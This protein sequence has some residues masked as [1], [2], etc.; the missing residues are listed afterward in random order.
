[1]HLQGVAHTSFSDGVTTSYVSSRDLPPTLSP[2]QAAVVLG[3]TAADFMRMHLPTTEPSARNELAE[4]F[5]RCEQNAFENY[6]KPWRD[7]LHA[8]V[9]GATTATAQRVVLGLSNCSEFGDA[10]SPEGAAVLSSPAATG[11]TPPVHAQSYLDSTAETPAGVTPLLDPGKVTVLR[12]RQ[13]NTTPSIAQRLP[14]LFHDRPFL[15]SKPLIFLPAALGH[16]VATGT[17]GHAQN[18]GASEQSTH[19]DT[20]TT[21]VSAVEVCSTRP[22]VKLINA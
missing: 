2:A 11:G 6:L 4:K 15:F 1:M 21:P 7:A 12:A 10:C 5:R 22:N 3:E 20:V 13:W 16:K 18:N 9:S 14:A 8:D 17:T 19:V